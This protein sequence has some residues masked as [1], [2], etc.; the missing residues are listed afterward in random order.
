MN[1]NEYNYRKT[2][3]IDYDYKITIKEFTKWLKKNPAAETELWETL[4]KIQKLS[5]EDLYFIAWDYNI[6][7]IMVKYLWAI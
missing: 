2:I 6:P 1:T 3:N 5:V 4:K 7:I